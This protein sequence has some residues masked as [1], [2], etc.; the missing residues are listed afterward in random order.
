MLLLGLGLFA[1]RPAQGQ[2]APKNAPSPVAPGDLSRPVFDTTTRVYDSV[3]SLEKAAST[4]VAEVEGRPITLGDVGDVIRSLPPA[5]EQLPFDS[6]YPGILEQLI[7][8]EALV[9]RA[10]QRGLD[11]DPTVRRR[12]KAASDR[13][14]SEEYLRIEASKAITET[15]LLDRYNRDFAGRPGPE[16]VRVRVILVGAEKDAADLI[17]EIQSGADFA[18]V[19]RRASTD[20]T[21]AAGGELGFRARDD[22][23]P[24]IAA[25][26]FTLT[27]GQVT[28]N[29][30][31]T[32]AGWFVIKVEERRQGPPPNFLLVR[33]QL[34]QTVLKEG[35]GALAE[36]ALQGLQVRRYNMTGKE[37]GITGDELNPDRVGGH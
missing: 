20:T 15:S 9:V 11:E 33:E 31:R 14:L 10:Q 8:Q 27:A 1:V 12:V 25:V 26:A 30:V 24:Q 29:P 34:R 3:A 2:T 5:V 18:T 7:K 35:V 4:V 36:T 19:A 32:S 21:A 17:A 22:M 16:E 23:N 28:P 13:A 6:L 37:V